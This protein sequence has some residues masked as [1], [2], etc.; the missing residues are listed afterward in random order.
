MSFKKTLLFGAAILATGLVSAQTTTRTPFYES[1]TSSTCPPCLG[2]NIHLEGLFTAPENEG[3]FT[4]L[5][6]QM[7]WPGTGDPYFTAEGG[8]RRSFYGIG[9]VPH[10]EIDG[11]FDSSPTSLDQDGMDAAAAV[12]SPVE[13]EAFFQVNEVTQTVTIQVDVTAL[14]ELES[15]G[16]LFLHCAIF[17]K[18]TTENVKTN[19]ETEFE[20]VMKKMVPGL[21]GT[22]LGGLDEGE[23][24][25]IDLE[26][27]FA[28]DYVLPPDAT[29]PIDHDDDHSVEEFSDLGV[30]VWVQ[31]SSTR[32][33][34]QSAYATAGMSSIETN[35]I[36]AITQLSIYP[37]PTSDMALVTY[38]TIADA[39][40]VT[41][42]I[43]DNAGKLIKE[44]LIANIGTETMTYNIDTENLDNGMYFV[45]LT[46]EQ[47]KKT[48]KLSVMH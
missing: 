43:Y 34:Y 14:Q 15:S 45:T 6:Y 28:G 5:K 13:L 4:S 27:V 1:F 38:S 2:G 17:E 47:G 9:G 7:S 36:E 31:R 39:G 29:D 26:H 11:G 16:G 25:T 22:Y 21:G 46:T 40:N 42:A 23:I 37:N 33:V 20:H 30:V 12:E 10:L 24:V 19:G 8:S 18:L 44:E 3:T 48:E 41:I 35:T 32:E